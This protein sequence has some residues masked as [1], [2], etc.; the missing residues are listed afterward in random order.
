[1]PPSSYSTRETCPMCLGGG[2]NPCQ[3]ESRLERWIVEASVGYLRAASPAEAFALFA[4]S[5][6]LC[7]VRQ[8]P[9]GVAFINQLAEGI[10]ARKGL[11]RSRGPWYHGRPVIINRNDYQ[12]R[13]FNGDIG[14]AWEDPRQVNVR[15]DASGCHVSFGEWRDAKDSAF[16]IA[17]A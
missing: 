12:V 4:R 11:A 3:L 17:G 5:R 15:P 16:E 14:I 7:A 8:G 6:I 10:L 13:L 1:M 2:R 9:F